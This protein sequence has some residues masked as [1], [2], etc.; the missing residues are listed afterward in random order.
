MYYF[1]MPYH[2]VLYIWNLECVAQLKSSRMALLLVQAATM[3]ETNSTR[4]FA[5][6]FGEE[7]QEKLSLPEQT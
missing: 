5:A 4:C 6:R 7:F 1:E 3:H 2:Y